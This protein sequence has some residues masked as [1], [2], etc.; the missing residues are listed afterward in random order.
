ML[1][2][3]DLRSWL[4]DVE[5]RGELK[6]IKGAHWDLE[7]SAII[8]IMAG[9]E[10]EPKPAV[11]FDDIP[12]YPKGFRTLFGML[13]S[14]WR[15]AKT[16]GLPEDQVAPLAPGI[17]DV[18][19]G[20]QLGPEVLQVPDVQALEVEQRVHRAAQAGVGYGTDPDL[21][22]PVVPW[23]RTMTQGQL[24]TAAALADAILPA[25]EHS[26]AASSVLTK[27]FVR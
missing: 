16:L 25:D 18:L 21:M 26:P 2:H 1:T 13:G 5:K 4:D 7:M 17:V 14:T 19:G 8:E 3:H 27:Q 11:I 12:G 9:K 6:T 23:S 22:H 10:I 15:I 24:Q 20:A